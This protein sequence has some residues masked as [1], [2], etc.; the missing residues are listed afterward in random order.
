LYVN[1]KHG[2]EEPSI[3]PCIQSLQALLAV[4][5]QTYIIINALD[6]CSKREGQHG[7]FA[8]LARIHSW[9]IDKLH[10][11]AISGQQVD[12]D[13]GLQTLRTGT[14]AIVDT[15]VNHDIKSYIDSRLNE[16][17]LKK[18]NQK[19]GAIDQIRRTVEGGAG[20]M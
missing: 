12:I 18:W 6:E 7:F 11:L 13:E 9:N 20:G 8:L 2:S 10:I 1:G 14:L 4:A 3:E 19:S 17:R 16:G 5:P 15:L